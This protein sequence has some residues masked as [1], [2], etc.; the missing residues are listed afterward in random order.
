MLQRI[1]QVVQGELKRSLDVLCRYGGEEFAV[2]LP[3]TDSEGALTV[4]ERMRGLIVGHDFAN[5]AHHYRVTV[6]I[7]AASLAPADADRDRNRLIALAD[8]AL[9]RAKKQGRNRVSQFVSRSRH[10]LTFDRT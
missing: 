2:V 8:Q 1:A 5:N 9:Y 3:D 6:S 7:G 4:A 10:P